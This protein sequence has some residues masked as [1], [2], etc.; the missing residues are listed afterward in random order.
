MHSKTLADNK[1]CVEGVLNS[2]FS[3]FKETLEN[4]W[5]L[6]TI[7]DFTKEDCNGKQIWMFGTSKQSDARM[8]L[9][10]NTNL[11]KAIV[12][13]TDEDFVKFPSL[14]YFT[15]YSHM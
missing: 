12:Y 1:F 6:D 5:Q 8:Y 11:I 10:I 7:N 3:N 14:D 2:S 15:E 4:D 9:T 13:C